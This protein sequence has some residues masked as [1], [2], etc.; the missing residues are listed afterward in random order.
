MKAKKGKKE[1]VKTGPYKQGGQT[2]NGG[3]YSQD[4]GYEKAYY[5]QSPPL[6]K[7][8]SNVNISIN[9]NANFGPQHKD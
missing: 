2:P 7:Q 3:G 1:K 4:V 5:G 8:G 9:I 6:H